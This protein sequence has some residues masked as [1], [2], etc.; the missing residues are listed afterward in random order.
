[1]H[2]GDR[3][4]HGPLQLQKS[5]IIERVVDPN[6]ARTNDWRPLHLAINGGGESEAFFL[7]NEAPE[8]D[9]DAPIPKGDTQLILAAGRGMVDVL[10][11]LPRWTACRCKR[12]SPRGR[13]RRRFVRSRMWQ[14]AVMTPTT[15]RPCWRTRPPF[16]CTA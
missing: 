12:L 8:V 3:T 15:R 1:M 13:K 5:L 2:H 16:P 4:T 11:A 9:V 7:I 14:W 6:E 10:R